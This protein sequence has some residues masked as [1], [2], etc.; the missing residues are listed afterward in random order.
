MCAC[1]HLFKWAC[2]AVLAH[3]R[4]CGSL[5]GQVD[6]LEHLCVC[7][8]ARALDLLTLQSP[9]SAHCLQTLSPIPLPCFFH[10]P[11][12]GPLAPSSPSCHPSPSFFYVA[13]TPE[14]C[15]H[16]SPGRGREREWGPALELRGAAL[17]LPTDL[18]PPV[19]AAFQEPGD[20]WVSS[21]LPP[22]LVCSPLRAPVSSLPWE[23]F[24]V[25][26]PESQEEEEEEEG[27]DVKP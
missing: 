9:F 2:C 11:P 3:M 22:S 24:E 25:L 16:R 26:S 4:A 6:V 19:G 7:V 8:C 5:C 23:S 13:G 21:F 15:W 20:R 12:S 1:V 10:L 14:R 18:S 17:S 27:E